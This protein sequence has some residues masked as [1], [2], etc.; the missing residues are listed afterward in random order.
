MPRSIRVSLAAL[1]LAGTIGCSLK[2]SHRV[3]RVDLDPAD[4]EA[5][6]VFAR[7]RPDDQRPTLYA[8][9]GRERR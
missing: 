9:D 7:L 5:A 6:V 4:D 2:Y 3:D 8:E 1:A